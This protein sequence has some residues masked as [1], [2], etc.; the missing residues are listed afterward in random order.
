MIYLT[1]CHRCGHDCRNH[2]NAENEREKLAV[3]MRGQLE[4]NID[5]KGE[6]NKKK[7]SVSW[8]K[9]R[10][11]ISRSLCFAANQLSR[12]LC[13]KCPL[14]FLF[15]FALFFLFILAFF[16]VQLQFFFLLLNKCE[17]QNGT[18]KLTLIVIMHPLSATMLHNM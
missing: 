16:S 1:Y 8:N 11:C 6:K 2:Y 10:I 3:K 17:P 18:E 12:S 5:R 4:Q 15:F 7:I 9:L 13:K 14:F